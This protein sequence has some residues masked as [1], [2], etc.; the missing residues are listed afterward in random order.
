MPYPYK[1]STLE[2]T[3]G[4]LSCHPGSFAH[5]ADISIEGRNSFI[6]AYGSTAREDLDEKVRLQR[7]LT[8]QKISSSFL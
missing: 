8:Q 7:T 4:W 5:G 1:L 3:A 2:D 6:T